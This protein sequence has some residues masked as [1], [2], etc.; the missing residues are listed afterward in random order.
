MAH[1]LDFKWVM[2]AAFLIAAV[3]PH[4]AT[5]REEAEVFAGRDKRIGTLHEG[6]QVAVLEESGEWVKIRFETMDASFDGYVK[7]A[8]LDRTSAAPMPLAPAAT[9]GLPAPAPPAAVPPEAAATNPAAAAAAMPSARRTGPELALGSHWQLQSKSGGI[10]AADLATLLKDAA[11]PA[12]NLVADKNYVLFKELYYLMPMADALRQFAQTS[13][14]AEPVNTPGFPVDS[15]KAYSFD[16]R[17][18]GITKLTLVADTK[19]QLVAVQTT[20]SG[21]KPPW[22]LRRFADYENTV[23]Y[24]KDL[25]LYDLALG[26]SKGSSNWRVGAIIERREGVVLIDTELI[27][28][29]PDYDAAVRSKERIRLHLPQ[30]VADLCAHLLQQR[31]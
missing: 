5:V 19:N 17:L 2:A 10:L 12:V 8:L 15:F 9:N 7:G 13:V 6:A 30:P 29:N 26:R 1:G 3:R 25:K 23:P 4:A 18:D 22:L 20:D 24:S 28:G 14:S 11:R 31:K 21:I 27:D 16:P